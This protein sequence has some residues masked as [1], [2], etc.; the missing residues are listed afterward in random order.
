MK[1]APIEGVVKFGGMMTIGVLLMCCFVIATHASDLNVPATVAAGSGLTIPASGSGSATLY[2]VG[3]GTAIKR[4]VQRG[5]EIR[6]S[7]E[8][9]QNAGRYVVSLDADSPDP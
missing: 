7:A 2:L 9:L 4:T 6:L 8:E 5:Q 1:K 3:P